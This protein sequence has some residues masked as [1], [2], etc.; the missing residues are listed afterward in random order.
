MSI[1]TAVAQAPAV[2]LDPITEDSY[3]HMLLRQKA[4]KGE[5]EIPNFVAP[6]YNYNLE[7]YALSDVPSPRGEGIIGSIS[8]PKD[9]VDFAAE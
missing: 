2:D 3:Q 1:I 5:I 6:T 4:E 7:T 9:I 8:D